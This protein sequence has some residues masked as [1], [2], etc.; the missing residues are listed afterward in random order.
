MVL[1]CV[2]VIELDIFFV[3]ELMGS[4]D[5]VMGEVVI[6]LMF[7][8]NCSVGFML[9]LVMYDCFVVVCCSCIFIIEVGYF[10]GDEIVIEF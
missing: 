8:L 2:F 10:V 3:D 5:I 6:V 9:V 1:V 7:E 4:F